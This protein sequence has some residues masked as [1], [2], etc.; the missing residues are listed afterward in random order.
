MKRT[1]LLAFAALAAIAPTAGQAIP[2]P[3]AIRIASTAPAVGAGSNITY[4]LNQAAATATVEIRDSGNAIVAT[5]PGTTAAGTNT[6]AWN[7][8][9]DNAAGAAVPVG[10]GYRVRVAVTG[11]EA[12]G[13]VRYKANGSSTSSPIMGDQDVAADW[14]PKGLAVN[15]D[16]DSDFFGS[17]MVGFGYNVTQPAAAVIEFTADLEVK[18]GDNGLASRRMKHP[19]DD[20]AAP[21][22]SSY[23]VWGLSWDPA[24]SNRLWYTGQATGNGN[25][26]AKEYFKGEGVGGVLPEFATDAD[27]TNVVTN[28]LSPRGIKI[29]QVGATRYAFITRSNAIIQVVALDA[30]NNFATNIGSIISATGWTSTNIRYS[31]DVRFDAA[32]NMYW[33]SQRIATVAGT[34]NGK[35]YRWDAAQ[36]AAAIADPVANVLTEANATWKITNDFAAVNQRIAGFAINAAGDVYVFSPAQGMFLVG[37]TSTATL[38]VGLNSLTPVLINT[39]FRPTVGNIN[40]G[41]SDFWFDAA[42]NLVCCDGSSENVFAFSPG[43]ASST[44]FTAPSSQTFNVVVASSVPDWMMY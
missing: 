16:P 28:G 5:F 36:V 4:V 6:V 2:F 25:G 9:V 15:N 19:G 44:A 20:A 40:A 29:Q 14:W 8:T 17:V 30:S 1:S 11:T 3:S 27:A 24:N 41:T 26:G 13:W 37:N 38:T 10:T 12:A 22:P 18:A 34:E 31:K 32:G 23:T 33:G 43:G 35:I 21:A 39:D 7:G 42:G